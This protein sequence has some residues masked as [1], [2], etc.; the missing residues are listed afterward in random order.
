[1]SQ[2]WLDYV[3]PLATAASAAVI[4]WQAW[5]TRSALKTSQIAL[6]E[7]QISRVEAQAPRL[8]VYAA[9]VDP[10]PMW[11]VHAPGAMHLDAV[12]IPNS[13]VFKLPRDADQEVILGAS[14]MFSNDGP[15][16]AILTVEDDSGDVFSEMLAIVGEGQRYEYWVKKTVAEWVRL[17]RLGGQQRIS[18]LTVR[19]EG[20]RDS[21]VSE[22]HVIEVH[23]NALRPVVDAEGD[24]RVIDYSDA[25][26]V[27]GSVLPTTRTYWKSRTRNETF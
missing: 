25:E 6:R 14:F 13:H 23:G 10:E 16:N 27:V 15:G 5:L 8:S 2:T 22:A 12:S 9:G 7:S 20:S 21:D 24:W 1:M 17:L 3:G 11:L 4:A 26:R 19:Y 18:R